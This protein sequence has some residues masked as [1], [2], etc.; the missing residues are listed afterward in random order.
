[1]NYLLQKLKLGAAR[2][3]SPS[4]YCYTDVLQLDIKTHRKNY[5]QKTVA[6]LNARYVSSIPQPDSVGR[7]SPRRQV[8]FMKTR[9][10][11]MPECPQNFPRA[12]FSETCK[13]LE[14]DKGLIRVGEW[15]CVRSLDLEKISRGET[16]IGLTEAHILAFNSY[17]KGNS[18]DDLYLPFGRFSFP[19][20]DYYTALSKA[21]HTIKSCNLEIETRWSGP[22]WMGLPSE[23]EPPT[24]HLSHSFPIDISELAGTLQEFSRYCGERALQRD[25]T[26]RIGYAV[27]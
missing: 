27:A 16:D 19:L 1:M 10:A 17:G 3:S 4:A 7:L 25:Y 23:H 9:V 11:E 2:L 8:E 18:L 22:A 20:W 26:R 13:R 24:I 14:Y 6:A 5:F 21:G 15:G 12:K